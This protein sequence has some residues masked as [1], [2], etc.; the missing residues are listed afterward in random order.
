MVM[1]MLPAG[2][3]GRLT[4]VPIAQR[5]EPTACP[6]CGV[7]MESVIMY[8]VELE[9]CPKDHGVWFDPEELQTGLLR[10]AANPARSDSMPEPL[11]QVPAQPLAPTQPQPPQSSR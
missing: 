4:L 2:V 3:L 5:K 10:S 7:Q 1:A 11:P 6:S 9:R 8:G